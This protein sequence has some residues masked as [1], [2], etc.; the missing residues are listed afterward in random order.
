MEVDATVV[1]EGSNP[2]VKL[3]E[4]TAADGR[5]AWLADIS[6]DETEERREGKKESQFMNPILDKLHMAN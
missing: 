3:A 4:E 5:L 2:D 1:E 6:V